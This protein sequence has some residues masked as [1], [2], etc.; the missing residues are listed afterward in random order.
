[1][2]MI[3]I[4]HSAT[5][6][7]FSLTESST[8]SNDA[9]IQCVPIAIISDSVKEF[10]ECFTFTISNTTSVA[11]LTLSPSESQI[12]IEGKLQTIMNL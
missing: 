12:C 2:K 11:G 7:F 4:P 5:D 10:E 1:M 9:L 3:Y 6:D 8:F